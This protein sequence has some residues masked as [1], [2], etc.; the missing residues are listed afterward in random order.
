MSTPSS[1]ARWRRQHCGRSSNSTVVHSPSSSRR[2]GEFEGR[3]RRT[4]DLEQ[5]FCAEVVAISYER[6]GLPGE[7]VT[8]NWFDP[9]KFWSGDR[10]ELIRAARGPEVSITDVPPLD[11]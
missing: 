10:L 2:E 11:A 3:A 6:M 4:A 1:A 8:A 7:R 5:L 9:G